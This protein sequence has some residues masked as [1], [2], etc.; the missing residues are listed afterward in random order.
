MKCYAGIATSDITPEIQ[1]ELLTA[2][3]KAVA[4]QALTASEADLKQSGWMCAPGRR[5]TLC[6]LRHITPEDEE[7]DTSTYAVNYVADS[8][9]RDIQRLLHAVDDLR[10]RFGL[11]TRA[12]EAAAK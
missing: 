8:M 1:P 11:R 2:A 7:K 6:M 9:D 12:E 4:G 5:A 3:N 10:R